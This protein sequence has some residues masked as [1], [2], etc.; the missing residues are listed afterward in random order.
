[1]IDSRVG[2]FCT[3]RSRGPVSGGLRAGRRT[4][5]AVRRR[6]VG[7][8]AHLV[9]APEHGASDVVGTTAASNG[10]LNRDG[11]TPRIHHAHTR[12]DES[13]QSRGTVAGRS[14]L[15]TL[16]GSRGDAATLLYTIR[17]PG[18][19]K[20]RAPG[21]HLIGGT[22]T[23]GQRESR[24]CRGQAGGDTGPQ[25]AVESS[26]FIEPGAP[27]PCQARCLPNSTVSAEPVSGCTRGRDRVAPLYRRV[28]G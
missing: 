26:V 28:R 2:A 4:V 3:D 9:S 11:P 24:R 14:R 19:G 13:A 6:T 18:Q 15:G 10:S 22:R 23:S 1:M 25:T 17:A 12:F 21:G 20:T 7:R 16:Q 5:G 8:R 27:D